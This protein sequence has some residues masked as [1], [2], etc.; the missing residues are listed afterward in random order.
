MVFSTL[1]RVLA[2]ATQPGRSGEYA[3]NPRRA[4]SM[5]IRYLI[6][7]M[8]AILAESLGR[9]LRLPRVVDGLGEDAG[10][11][12]RGVEAHR[13]LGGDEVDAPLRLALQRED[14]G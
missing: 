6:A 13:V 9:E 8:I 11:L 10:G 12:G 5:T 1:R 2:A 3:E 7:S 14:L 4:F